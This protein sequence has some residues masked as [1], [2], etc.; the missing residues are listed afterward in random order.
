MEDGNVSIKSNFKIFQDH[1][2]AGISILVYHF[3]LL[4]KTLPSRNI[5]TAKKVMTLKSI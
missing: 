5:I 3:I 1:P 4:N 2:I